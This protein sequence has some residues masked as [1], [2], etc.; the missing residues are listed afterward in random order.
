VSVPSDIRT[1]CPEHFHK[2]LARSQ[3]ALRGRWKNLWSTEQTCIVK[4]VDCEA[5]LDKLVYTAANPCRIIWSTGRCR[6][7]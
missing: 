3:N 2:L 6:S 4:L 1:R 5:V 7:I